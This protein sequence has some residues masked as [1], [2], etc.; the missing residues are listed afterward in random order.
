MKNESPKHNYNPTPKYKI[1]IMIYFNK[2]LDRLYC[3]EVRESLSSKTNSY[4]GDYVQGYLY[5]YGILENKICWR[6]FFYKKM[7]E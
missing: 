5:F 2:P 1:K 4:L 7:R 6:I 3:Q